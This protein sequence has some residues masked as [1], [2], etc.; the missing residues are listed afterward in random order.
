MVTTYNLVTLELL[1][2]LLESE[3]CTAKLSKESQFNSGESAAK[4]CKKTQQV[5][6]LQTLDAASFYPKSVHRFLAIRW[7]ELNVTEVTVVLNSDILKRISE[8]RVNVFN[9]KIQ[10]TRNTR[11]ERP[12]LLQ[13]A[14]AAHFML[15]LSVCQLSVNINAK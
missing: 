3:N 6:V 9:M 5:E 8:T 4:L 11:D 12:N 15:P 10:I 13:F 7:N 2:R 1:H 14:W